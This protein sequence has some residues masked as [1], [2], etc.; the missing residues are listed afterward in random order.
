MKLLLQ[1]HDRFDDFAEITPE[2]GNLT[3]YSKTRNSDRWRKDTVGF[4]AEVNA[5]PALL[6][7]I[8]HDLFWA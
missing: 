3:V 2:T 8:N 1:S 7:R 5:S 6:F 4:F